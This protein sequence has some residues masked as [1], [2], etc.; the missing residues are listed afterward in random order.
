MRVAAQIIPSGRGTGGPAGDEVGA[1]IR[2]VGAR[3]SGDLFVLLAALGSSGYG[4]MDSRAVYL[5]IAALEMNVL[6]CRVEVRRV[7]AL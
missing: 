7:L 5:Y 1:H 4:L 2:R 3:L 6:N